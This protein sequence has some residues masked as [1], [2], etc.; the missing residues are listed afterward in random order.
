MCPHCR[1]DWSDV[2]VSSLPFCYQM[3]EDVNELRCSEHRDQLVIWCESCSTKVCVSCLK[4]SHN[5]CNWQPL[6][7]MVQRLQNEIKTTL[8]AA[9]AACVDKETAMVELRTRTKRAFQTTD[10]IQD[11]LNKAR[12]CL[13]DYCHKLETFDKKLLDYKCSLAD[14]A[15]DEEGDDPVDDD[16]M[17]R[18]LRRRDRIA[19]VARQLNTSLPASPIDAELANL[20]I[21]SSGEV[22]SGNVLIFYLCD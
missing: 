14:V 15:E 8:D 20:G 5:R 10:K 3:V 1:Q 13:S 21:A 2:P 18:L 22:H 19:S 16:L 9:T 12:K 6:L 7:G 4:Y 17:Y 11:D